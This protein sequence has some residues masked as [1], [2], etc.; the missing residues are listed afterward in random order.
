L[1]VETGDVIRIER[2]AVSRVGH[3]PVRPL[4]VDGPLVGDEDELGLRARRKLLYNGVVFL[5]V[6][7][8]APENVVIYMPGVPDPSGALE[9][10]IRD[11]V[12]EAL[13]PAPHPEGLGAAR[14]DLQ[15]AVRRL[16]RRRTEKRPVVTA[17]LTP[18]PPG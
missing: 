13:T 17:I 14:D 6:L 16:I 3:E 5:D 1:V 9:D 15:A 8:A 11:L 4:F 18:S 2:G 12:E 7:L 10:D